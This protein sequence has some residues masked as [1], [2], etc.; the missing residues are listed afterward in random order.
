LPQELLKKAGAKLPDKGEK[1]KQQIA[2]YNERKAVL[3]E[4]IS[5][6]W[7]LILEEIDF[8]SFVLPFPSS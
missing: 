8:F 5:G 1:L 2:K 4:S 7:S 3:D 6:K